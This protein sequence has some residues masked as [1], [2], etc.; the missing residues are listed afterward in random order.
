MR[1]GKFGIS[2]PHGGLQQRCCDASYYVWTLLFMCECVC[3]F[4]FQSCVQVM[5]KEREFSDL[6]KGA[7]ELDGFLN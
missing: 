1:T 2:G 3:V 5:D 6:E 4:F 7:L